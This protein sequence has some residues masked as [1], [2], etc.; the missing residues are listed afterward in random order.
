MRAVGIKFGSLFL[1]C[2]VARLKTADGKMSEKAP[3]IFGD[4]GSMF[5]KK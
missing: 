4:I 5:C 3:T 2:D 1:W